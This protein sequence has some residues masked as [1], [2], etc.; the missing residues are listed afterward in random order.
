[1]QIYHN[2]YLCQRINKAK[3]SKASPCEV[4]Y[5]YHKSKEKKQQ[6]SKDT[7]LDTRTQATENRHT[8]ND[9]ACHEIGINH[10]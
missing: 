3:A 1:M 5:N 9:V 6:E 7:R 4:I 10:A 8:Q 2:I